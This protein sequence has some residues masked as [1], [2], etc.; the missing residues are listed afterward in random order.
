MC[1]SF[2][3][4]S[5]GRCTNVDNLFLSAPAHLSSLST[6]RAF[7]PN[8]LM[9]SES[10]TKL[11]PVRPKGFTLIGPRILAPFLDPL[12]LDRADESQTEHNE[13]RLGEQFA[14][15][16]RG[17]FQPC[18]VEIREKAFLWRG[19]DRAEVANFSSVRRAIVI[20]SASVGRAR[21]VETQTR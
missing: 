16:E 21:G 12:S 8:C 10:Q 6:V 1:Q 5:R 20:A 4:R 13:N 14:A 2:C 17:E 7:D 15:A 19:G 11:L 9:N 18:S 3:G